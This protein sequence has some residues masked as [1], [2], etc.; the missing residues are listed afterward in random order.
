MAVKTHAAVLAGA[1]M[2]CSPA[3]FSGCTTYVPGGSGHADD[4]Y[5]YYSTAHQPQTVALVYTRTAGT[6]WTYEIPVNRQLTI[7]FYEDEY[8]NTDQPAQMQWREFPIGTKQGRLT[9]QMAV[10]DKGNRRV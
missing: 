6:L 1:M 3:L 2:L 7:A 8:Q 4:T 9:S 5:T 10:T